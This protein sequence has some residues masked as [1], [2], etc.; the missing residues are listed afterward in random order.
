MWLLILFPLHPRNGSDGQAEPILNLQDLSNYNRWFSGQ[1]RS[2]MDR[3]CSP[4]ATSSGR[5]LCLCGALIYLACPLDFIP[6]ALFGLIGFMA[7]F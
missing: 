5:I 6:K 7:F 1:P 3:R 2:L 4:W